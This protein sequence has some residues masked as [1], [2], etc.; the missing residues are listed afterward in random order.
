MAQTAYVPRLREQFDKEIRGK[1]VEQFGYRPS[2]SIEDGIGRFIAW[3][4][5]YFKV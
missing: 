4:R 2:T 1:L 3:Y 5:D